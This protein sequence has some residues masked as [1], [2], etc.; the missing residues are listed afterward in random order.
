MYKSKY[1]IYLKQQNVFYLFA[2]LL[3][4]NTILLTEIYTLI[5]VYFSPYRLVA[6]LR[7]IWYRWIKRS[8]ISRHTNLNKAK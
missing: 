6:Y 7:K 3:T 2:S 5:N 8:A 1:I 4:G